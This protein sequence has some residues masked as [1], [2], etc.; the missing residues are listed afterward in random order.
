MRRISRIVWTVSFLTAMI[1]VGHAQ[2]TLEPQQPETIVVTSNL[3]TLNVIVTDREGRYVKAL[4][5][6]L[7]QVDRQISMMCYMQRQTNSAV[8]E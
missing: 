1:A 4:K 5:A 7:A 6:A 3:V 8:R 2:T